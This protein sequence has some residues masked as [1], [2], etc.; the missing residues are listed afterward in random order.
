MG[1][2]NIPQTDPR[3]GYLARREELDDAIA[4][5]LQGGRYILGAE[6]KAFEEEFARYTGTGHAVGVASGTDAISLALRACG[7]GPGDTVLTVS[8]TAVA[9]VAAIELAGATPAFVDVDPV[10]YTMDPASLEEAIAVLEQTG[11][12]P[13]AVIVVHLYGQPAD[14]E[15]IAA[16]ARRHGLLVVEDC[17]QAHGSMIGDVRVG[18]IGDIA[19]FSFYPTKNLGAFGDGGAVT[20]SDSD[21]AARLGELREYGWRE[22]YVSAITGTNSRLDE[23]HA[24]MLRVKL[25][26][27][28]S[29]NARRRQIASRYDSLLNGSECVL[30][31]QS[32]DTMHVYHQYVIRT[33]NRDDLR[34]SLTAQGIG[35][36][37]HYPVPVHCQPAYRDRIGTVVPMTATERAAGEILSLPMFPELTDAQSDLV[38]EGVLAERNQSISL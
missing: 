22:R 4:R 37:I 18:S 17:A 32:P 2:I 7:I 24:A 1:I 23:L 11:A 6:V 31:A 26:Y 12:R 20:T 35:T 28:D 25:R 34:E 8:H 10:R 19:A 15:T 21:V 9:T 30:P 38:I 14:M 33:R 5:T 27:L 13:R 16:I 3:A 36:L 29:D